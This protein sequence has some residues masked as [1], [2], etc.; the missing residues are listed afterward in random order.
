MKKNKQ[1]ILICGGEGSRIKNIYTKT[2]KS[3]IKFNQQPFINYQI[4]WLLKNKISNLYICTNK[5]SSEIIDYVK[6]KNIKNLKIK[7]SIE[8]KKLG[9]GGAI[10]NLIKN[11]YNEINDQF[12]IMYGDSFLL[13]N[14]KDKKESNNI[15]LMYIY[16]NSNR[17]DTSNV[18]INEDLLTIYYDKFNIP[19]NSTHI[20]YGISYINKKRFMKFAKN[21]SENFDLSNYFTELSKKKS[22]YFIEA[23]K[24]FF[25]VGSFR[26]IKNFRTYINDK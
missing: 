8:K 2:P 20:D 6:S 5:K 22:L 13:E 11:K 9:T 18:V 14:I 12:H 26:G 23:K 1:L 21:T 10:F 16:K 25:E 4:E 24:K 3:L 7:F 17:Y 15:N 19:S